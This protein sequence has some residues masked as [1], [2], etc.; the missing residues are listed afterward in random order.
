RLLL[1]LLIPTSLCSLHY[2]C[3]R[4]VPSSPRTVF[5]FFFNGTATTT[6]YTLSLHDALPISPNTT[7]PLP[8]NVCVPLKLSAPYP[9]LVLPRRAEAH[10]TK[11]LFRGHFAV[12]LMV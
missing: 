7:V 8:A 11:L 4:S 10:K 12:L 9:L 5:P 3:Y 2:R 1:C 6:T